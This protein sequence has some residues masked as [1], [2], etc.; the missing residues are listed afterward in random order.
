[1]PYISL[2]PYY[3]TKPLIMYLGHIN[4][5]MFYIFYQLVTLSKINK[6]NKCNRDF[7]YTCNICNFYY[8]LFFDLM[9]IVLRKFIIF[10]KL[11]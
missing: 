4:K 10:F 7:N 2:C 3:L 11:L 9:S 1:M 8:I 5:Y 6:K